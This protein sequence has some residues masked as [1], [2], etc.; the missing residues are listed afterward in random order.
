MTRP[1][2]ERNRAAAPEEGEGSPATLID[3]ARGLLRTAILSGSIAP[4]TKLKIEA[5]Q[6]EFALSSSPL[7]EALNRLV[8]EGL[9][10]TIGRRGF[11]AAP[12]TAED[13]VDLTGFRL[14]LETGA[15]R[16]SIELGT[17]EW[18]AGVA[19]AYYR[20]EVAEGKAGSETRSANP[21][22]RDRHKDFHMSLFGACGSRRLID[23]CSDMYDQAER[24][25]RYSMVQRNQERKGR[26]EHQQ[27]MKAALAR[28]AAAAVQLLRDHIM[29]TSEHVGKLLRQRTTASAARRS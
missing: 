3:T 10:T 21:H 18:E 16:A 1:L 5:L 9:V 28:D 24:Y 13:L 7:R 17:D 20:L 14:V 27:I 11:H 29:E 2:G 6:R 19:S 22:W 8:V 12:I 4:G 23:A 25:R 15:L 26:S